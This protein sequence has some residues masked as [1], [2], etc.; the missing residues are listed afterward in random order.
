LANLYITA[1]NTLAGRTYNDITQY[2]VVGLSKSNAV[3]P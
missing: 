1:L 2:P 3:D